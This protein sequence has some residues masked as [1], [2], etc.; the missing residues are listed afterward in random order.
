MNVSEV[1]LLLAAPNASAGYSS[2]GTVYNSNGKWCSTTQLNTATPLNNLFPDLTGP[3]NAGRQVDY[4]CLFVYNTDDTDTMINVWAWIPSSSVLGPINWAIGADTTGTTSYN[5]IIQQAGYIT[6]PTISPSTVS[7][8]YAPSA[9]A[10]GG[11]QLT[12]IGPSQV[13]AFWIRRTAT[14]STAYTGDSFEIQVT[15]DTSS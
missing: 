13:A 7:A 4:Q 11:A 5:S 3:Q 1:Q 15:W 8:W 14:N 12:S 9:T 10:S 2:P 6:S